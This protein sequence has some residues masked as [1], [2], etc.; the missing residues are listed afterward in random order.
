MTWV[1]SWWVHSATR[2]VAHVT[3]PTGR[4]S[5]GGEP[6]HTLVVVERIGAPSRFALDSAARLGTHLVN[7]ANDS[8]VLAAAAELGR[9]G[10]CRPLVSHV[11]PLDD[12]VKAHE[13]AAGGS[14][15]VVVTLP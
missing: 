11:V 10:H 15:K 4:V 6:A 12:V 5:G 2:T 3:S 8:A 14:G 9:D 7:A 13:L 1:L